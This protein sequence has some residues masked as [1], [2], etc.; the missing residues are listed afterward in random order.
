MGCLRK[1]HL[2]V[3]QMIYAVWLLAQDDIKYFYKVNGESVEPNLVNGAFWDSNQLPCP[4]LGQ[5]TWLLSHMP[6]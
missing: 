1:N 4:R 6:P 2:S 3:F 5:G